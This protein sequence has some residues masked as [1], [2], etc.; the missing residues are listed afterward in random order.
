[1][2][3]RRS[4]SSHADGGGISHT[5]REDRDLQQS[6]EPPSMK[7]LRDAIPPHCFK[8]NG[9]ISMSYI[10]RD[11]ICIAALAISATYI[12]LVEST[13]LRWSLWSV[14]GFV[15]GLFFTGLWILAHECGH[16]ALFNQS[17]LNNTFG[18]TLHS[19]LCVPFYSWKY[20]HGR[21]H[22]YTNHM[23]RD[24]AFVPSREGQS[25][26]QEAIEKLFD[27]AEDTPVLSL[28]MLVGHQVL[29]WPLYLLFEI[30]AGSRSSPVPEERRKSSLTR[31]HFD[32]LAGIYT[33]E[34]APFILLS[35][36]GLMATA[37]GLYFLAQTVGSSTT[38]LLYVLPY[39]WVNHWIGEQRS[40]QG[41]HSTDQSQS[42]LLSCTTIIPTSRITRPMLGA[43]KKALSQLLTESLASSVV[44][45]FMGSSSSM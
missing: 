15:Q 36:L 17:I 16:G 44:T 9:L 12:P 6:R 2:H 28:L 25:G 7:A 19:F 41:R 11:I 33:R 30:T 8:P 20:S 22:R 18:F 5:K 40:P 27:L 38:A 39:L 32:P 13:L 4:P 43:F 14:Y 31:S 35:D 21:H 45:S 1:M 10:F 23:E 42:Q 26:V 29:G 34:Q 37:T 3:Q 24:T